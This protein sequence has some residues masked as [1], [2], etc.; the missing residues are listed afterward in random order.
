MDIKFANDRNGAINQLFKLWL[1]KKTI[2]IEYN[3]RGLEFLTSESF[4]EFDKSV[5]KMIINILK[6]FI[7][8]AEQ[9][10][11]NETAIC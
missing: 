9:V 4:Y 1:D 2:T 11:N 10:I 7:D 6:P 8:K 5:I 3:L